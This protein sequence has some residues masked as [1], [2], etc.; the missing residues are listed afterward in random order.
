MEMKGDVKM[1]LLL[2]VPYAEKEDAKG[3]GARWNPELKKW[4][5]D[6]ISK[7][8]DIEK[9][10]PDFNILCSKIVIFE[11]DRACWKCMQNT[12]VVCLASDLSFA[13]EDQ[14][15]ENKNLQLFSYIKNMPEAL[16][17]HLKAKYDY[18]PSYSKQID[19]TYFMNH[20]NYCNSV[21]GDNYLHEIP[22]DAFYKK[23]CY[24]NSKP[25]SY[26]TIENEFIIPLAA[27]LPYYDEMSESADLMF[28]H[29]YTGIENRESLDIT[30][31]LINGLFDKSIHLGSVKI[32]GI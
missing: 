2:N 15:K 9:W 11:M 31:K 26:T 19:E 30:Q 5:V 32:D 1:N 13:P 24:V 12:L 27:S 22:E 10:I 23:L 25:S 16:Q 4:Y 21:Q 8:P 29:I 28:Q 3:K 6:D 7:A 14:Y 18:S 20:C 17:I